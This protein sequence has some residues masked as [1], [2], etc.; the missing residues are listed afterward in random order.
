MAHLT[1][2][3]RATI[4]RMIEEGHQ[5]KVIARAIGRCPSVVSREK[6]RN[7][8]GRSGEYRAALAQRKYEGRVKS[9]PVHRR[10]TPQMRARVV[11]LLGRKY[12]PEQIVGTA[13]NEG[14]E[15][16]SH[17]R[18][19]QHVWQDKRAGGVLHT[20]LRRRGRR[21][22]K[23]GAAK[24]TRGIIPGRV[25]IA[26][27]P[28]V[29]EQR[30]R[31]GDLEIDTIIGKGHQGAIVTINDRATG[32]LRMFKVDRREAEAVAQGTIAALKPW[33]DVLHTITADNGKEFALHA[34]IA[35]ELDVGFFF[36]RPYHSWERG[37][38]ENLNGLIR[39]YIPKKTDFSTLT[40]EYIAYVQNELN[41]RPRK[42]LGYRSPN[43]TF[44]QLTD[45][46]T[47]AF[48]G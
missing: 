20:H 42:R 36:A 28:S 1:V 47:I 6:A 8:D 25:D 16:V 34:T 2:E 44:D 24:D 7:G 14:W 26:Q 40:D 38:N 3:E 21:Y 5:Q 17:E 12:S 35:Q 29:V 15:C 48:R 32:L 18:I 33:G 37:S 27:R 4:Q 10:Y 46:A 41:D 22:R 19:Y 45:Q 23:R 30:E 31:F 43:A 39:Q 9:K 11:A 13:A